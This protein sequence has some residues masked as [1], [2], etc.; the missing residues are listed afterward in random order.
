VE[1]KKKKPEGEPKRNTIPNDL[2]QKVNQSEIPFDEEIHTYFDFFLSNIAAWIIMNIPT[3][4]TEVQVWVVIQ[5]DIESARE[6]LRLQDNYIS[7][8]LKIL[9]SAEIDV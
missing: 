3:D 7:L 4:N 8:V 2:K 9:Y 1:G 6:C 5:K